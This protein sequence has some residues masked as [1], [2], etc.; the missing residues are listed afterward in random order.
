MSRSRRSSR[1]ASRQGLLSTPTCCSPVARTLGDA[2][3]PL[4]QQRPLLQLQITFDE[5]R[6]E[7]PG[8]DVEA[9]HAAAAQ[10]LE[11]LPAARDE[12][13]GRGPLISTRRRAARRRQCAT[14]SRDW[15][16]SW[17]SVRITTIERRPTR[18]AIWVSAWP[19]SGST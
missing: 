6:A 16:G 10:Q 13:L 8:D 12:L 1:S 4:L 14:S 2:M 19:K 7:V 18:R 9:Q 15:F 5:R 11:A 3:P 17:T